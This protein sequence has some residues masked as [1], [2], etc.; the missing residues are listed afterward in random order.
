MLYSSVPVVLFSF[1]G[2]CQTVRIPDRRYRNDFILPSFQENVYGDKVDKLWFLIDTSGSISD[3][4]L[5]E[6][7][8][9]IR[10][11]VEQIGNLSGELSFFDTDV[12]EPKPFESVEELSCCEPIGGGGT[13][14]NAIFEYLADHYENDLPNAVII[15]TD[16]YADF[17]DEDAAL[18]L[19][20]MWIII[21]S[22]VDA[23]WGECIHIES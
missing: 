20:V 3:E 14:F 7:Y 5:S 22:D 10:D 6:A 23:P 15:L 19:P 13:S 18:G 4:A 12:T 11:S 2:F 16:G 1:Q 8:L 21:D 9:E 17:P